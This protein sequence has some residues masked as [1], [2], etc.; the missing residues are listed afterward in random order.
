MPQRCAAIAAAA[1]AGLII[2]TETQELLLKPM[3]AVRHYAEALA[4][5]PLQEAADILD[6]CVRGSH[7]TRSS[8]PPLV[9]LSLSLCL[10]LSDSCAYAYSV[11]AGVERLVVLVGIQRHLWD[12][13][14][15]RR[16]LRVATVHPPFAVVAVTLQIADDADRVLV[17]EGVLTAIASGPHGTHGC[18]VFV[19]WRI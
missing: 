17:R 18:V 7:A 3:H 19:S 1:A 2:A 13:E 15:C 11:S 16:Q 9:P 10:C 5:S 8:L 12:V 6:A 14:V 4:A